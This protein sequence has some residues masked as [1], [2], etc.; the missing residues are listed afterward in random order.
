MKKNW[1]VLA[2]FVAICLAV[3]L[4]AGWATSRSVTEWYPTLEKP[5]WTPPAALFAPVWTILYVMMAIAAWLVWRDGKR[6]R[7]A[8]VFF[9]VQLFL[10]GLW[11]FLF[12]GLRMPGLALIEILIL[13]LMILV[14][15]ISFAYRSTPAALMMAPYLAWVSFAMLLNASIWRLN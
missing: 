5:E 3:G 8:L 7:R 12:F 13:W 1:Q 9:F 6:P 10:N 11:S 14:T 2:L 4:L 15:L